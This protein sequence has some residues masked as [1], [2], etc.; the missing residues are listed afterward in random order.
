MSGRR[1]RAQIQKTLTAQGKWLPDSK[2]ILSGLANSYGGYFTTTEEYA[3]QRYEGSSTLFGPHQVAAALQAFDNLAT[4]IATNTINIPVRLPDT[5]SYFTVQPNFV[6]SDD[7]VP[8]GISWGE[9]VQVSSAWYY[10]DNNG[11]CKGE[12]KQI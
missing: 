3:R 1:V 6:P 12:G 2:V 4:S 5:R 11:F 8:N 10:G 9:T 7:T